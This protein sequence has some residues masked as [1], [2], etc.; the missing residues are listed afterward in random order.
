[1]KHC[2]IENMAILEIIKKN[3]SGKS[4]SVE[5]IGRFDFCMEQFFQYSIFWTI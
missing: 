4:S 2:I 1:M 5:N 3:I